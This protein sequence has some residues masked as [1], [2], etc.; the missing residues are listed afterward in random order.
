M[1]P[2]SSCKAAFLQDSVRVGTGWERNLNVVGI[3]G[4]DDPTFAKVTFAPGFFFS[5]KG[6]RLRL[7]LQ[8]CIVYKVRFRVNFRVLCLALISTF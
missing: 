2:V 1:I 5:S 8:L 7:E 4:I 3:W 6:V